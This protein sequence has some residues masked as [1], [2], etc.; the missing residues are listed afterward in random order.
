[1]IARLP[2]QLPD[3]EKDYAVLLGST[4]TWQ[5][6]ASRELDKS[7]SC[8]CRTDTPV[9]PIEPEGVNPLH[10]ASVLWELLTAA[11][12]VMVYLDDHLCWP[13]VEIGRLVESRPNILAVGIATDPNWCWAGSL[14]FHLQSR[15]FPVWSTIPE[16]L[17]AA[18]NLGRQE[19]SR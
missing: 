19:R 13:L 16:T 7:F 8:V 14:K 10:L 12:A 15:G 1:M 5:G 9:A 6:P 11:T 4:G 3:P 17:T 18:R 2:Y